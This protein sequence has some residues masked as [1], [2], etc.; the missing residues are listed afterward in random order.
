MWLDRLERLDALRNLVIRYIG[1]GT[2]EQAEYYNRNQ[3]VASFHVG[4][5]VLW[6]SNKL[7]NAS[8]RFS[9]KFAPK[10][11]CPYEILRQISN[12]IYELKT[13]SNRRI[14]KVH[15]S[16]LKPYIPSRGQSN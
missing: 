14:A 11:D 12:N 3:R 2:D 4:D 5:L 15:V 8:Q 7:S 1:Q 6:R 9:A 16:N 13:E 10:F